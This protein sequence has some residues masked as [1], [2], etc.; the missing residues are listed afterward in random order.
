MKAPTRVFGGYGRLFR[1]ADDFAALKALRQGDHALSAALQQQLTKKYGNHDF[2]TSLQHFLHLYRYVPLEQ[3]QQLFTSRVVNE[4]T[5]SAT[6]APFARCFDEFSARSYSDQIMYSFVHLHLPGLLQRVDTTTMAASVE[7]RVPFVDHRL[8]ELAFRIN[9]QDKMPFISEQARRQA[10]HK[11]GDQISE[12][13][14]NPKAILKKLVC[15]AITVNHYQPQ[16]SGLS[17]ATGQL[18]CG[19]ISAECASIIIQWRGL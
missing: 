12:H 19:R 14:D 18:V 2:S 17:G 15:R 8:V 16:K 13:L 5:L 9:A 7:A 6:E 10:Q 4:Q 1:S 11:T 3:Q